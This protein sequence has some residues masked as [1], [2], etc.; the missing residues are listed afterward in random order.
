MLTHSYASI[1]RLVFVVLGLAGSAGE[2]RA[3][4]FAPD[5]GPKVPVSFR[6]DFR[7][8]WNVTDGFGM[9]DHAGLSLTAGPQ[10][11][12]AEPKGKPALAAILGA[13]A[14]VAE[15]GRA[16]LRIYGGLESVS[17]LARDVELVPSL[18]LGYLRAFHD[19]L[20]QGPMLRVAL[21]LRVFGEKGFFLVF[22][23]LALLVLPPPPSGFTPYTSHVAWD[24][25]IVKLGG[26][27]P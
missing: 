12:R 5:P 1:A 16:S 21:G 23:P 3:Q 19:D 18:H 20:R 25:G 7:A 8:G 4:D 14:G 9:I 2:A 10:F 11:G 24:I 17:A 6:V 13:T 22:E 26:R 15:T 27:G